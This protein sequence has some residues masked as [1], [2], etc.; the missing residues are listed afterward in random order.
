MG[1]ARP[2]LGTSPRATFFCLRHVMS[3]HGS[4]KLG[5]EKLPLKLIGC[6]YPGSE[7]RDLLS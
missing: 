6:V 7:L 1:W 3:I 2:K 5:W 4:A